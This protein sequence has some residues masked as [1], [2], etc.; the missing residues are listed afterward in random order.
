M[1]K[2]K[3]TCTNCGLC[4]KLCPM[5]TID[6]DDP[7][8]MTGICIKCCACVKSCPVQAR[9][10]DDPGVRFHKEDLEEKFTSPAKD[11]EFYL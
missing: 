1:P 6:P 9:Y 7:F 4:A 3:D 8:K 10:F 5:G 11:P 2:T